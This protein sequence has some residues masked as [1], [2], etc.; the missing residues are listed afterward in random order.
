MSNVIEL[1]PQPTKE[2]KPGTYFCNLCSRDFFKIKDN[3]VIEC[4]TCGVPVK[5]LEATK[6]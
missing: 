1:R 5:N 4:Y 2:T 3:G 6:K